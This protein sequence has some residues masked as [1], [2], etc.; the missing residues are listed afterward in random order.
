MGVP[1]PASS[2]GPGFLSELPLSKA[3]ITAPQESLD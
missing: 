2:V 1:P 3:G